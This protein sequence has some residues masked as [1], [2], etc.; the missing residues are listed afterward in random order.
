MTDA[1]A[2]RLALPGI[3]QNKFAA[4]AAIAV[5]AFAGWYFL[6][7]D[8]AK[9]YEFVTNAI[10]QGLVEQS[11]SATGAVQ[12]L[13]TV[14]LSSQLSGQVAEVA[15]DF[16][17]KVKAGELL[18]VLDKKSFAAKVRS[19]EANLAMAMAGIE[20][21][22]AAIRKNEALLEKARDDFARQ[23]S[24]SDKGATSTAVLDAART[25]LATAEADL[26]VA[27]AQL[28][29]A[30]A[31]LAQRQSEVEQARIDLDRTEIRSP[32]NG[33]V[34]DRSIDPGATVAASL[35]APILFKIAQDLSRIQ[36]ETQVDEADIGKIQEGNPVSFTVDAFPDRTFRGTVAQVRIGGTTE[37]NVV[38]Y[39]VIV[40]AP[41]QRERLLPGM[42][43]TVRI[44]TGRKEQALRVANAAIRFRPP[45]NIPGADAAPRWGRTEAFIAELTELL[46]LDDEQVARLRSGLEE[47]RARRVSARSIEAARGNGEQTGRRSQRGDNASSRSTGQRER[48]NGG[49]FRIL[50]GI[51]T[52]EQAKVFDKWREERRETTRA[53]VVW[54]REGEK[55]VPRRVRL[56]LADEAYSEVVAGALKKGD[57]VVTRIKEVRK[58]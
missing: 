57:E 49:L 54:L 2:T 11:I 9:R 37:G 53:A 30:R 8:D 46:K 24:L 29:N 1:L 32:I 15:V 40:H 47:L 4:A 13:E 17:S 52:E 45:S 39:T 42:T 10:D 43:A 20:V 25:T 14:E 19:A 12:A 5:L 7:G 56:G 16:N 22:T 35:Q 3:L 33:V 18:A 23:K 58:P 27:K 50:R 28:A 36:I 55:L 21:Q 26:G 31:Q 41:N 38:T 51:L 48:S 44:V 6:S 34:I